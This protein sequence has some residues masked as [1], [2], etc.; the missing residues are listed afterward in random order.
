MLDFSL[1]PKGEEAYHEAVMAKVDF[2]HLTL[3][4]RVS[5]APAGPQS[6][7]LLLPGATV[8]ESPHTSRTTSTM[9]FV[10]ISSSFFMSFSF[11]CFQVLLTL[12]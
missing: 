7:E 5:L 10:S 12:Q 9:I 4:G 11:R 1:P 2:I 8:V 6:A 3:M